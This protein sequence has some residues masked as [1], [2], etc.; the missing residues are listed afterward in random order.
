MECKTALLMLNV[1][2]FVKSLSFESDLRGQLGSCSLQK[3][4]VDLILSTPKR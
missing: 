3:N 1:R 4:I 2:V